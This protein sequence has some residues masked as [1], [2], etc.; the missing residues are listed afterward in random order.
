MLQDEQLSR[1]FT[2]KYNLMIDQN[3]LKVYLTQDIGANNKLI[4]TEQSRFYQ[5][6]LYLFTLIHSDIPSNLKRSPSMCKKNV[7]SMYR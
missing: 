4:F 2:N 1:V 3:F 5:K 6:F 7:T